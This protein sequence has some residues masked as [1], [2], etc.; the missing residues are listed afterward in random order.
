CEWLLARG[1]KVCQ[2]FA[3]AN[4][5]A[6]MAPL[7]RSGFRHTTQLVSLQ[8]DVRTVEPEQGEYT[9]E[10]SNEHLPLSDEFRRVALATRE[11]TLDC[12]ELTGARTPEEL[13]AGF[14][15]PA[16]SGGLSLYRE[17]GEPVGVVMHT[18]RDRETVEL[19]YLGVVPPHRGRGI[20]SQ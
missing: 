8:R 7:E 5:V 2:A 13:L 9:L 3:S 15:A 10:W 6:D 1:V 20:G 16:F 17:R 18:D 4:E 11:G 14:D 19:T 12:P